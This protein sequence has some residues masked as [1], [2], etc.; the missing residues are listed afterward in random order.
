[1]FTTDPHTKTTPAVGGVSQ[2]GAVPYGRA[3]RKCLNM[4]EGRAAQLWA[5]FAN[6][7]GRLDNAALS[8]L[9]EVL[10]GYLYVY[11]HTVY[12]Y[13]FRA[14]ARCCAGKQLSVYNVPGR[15]CTYVWGVH[16]AQASG[17]PALDKD[18]YDETC[19]GSQLWDA[20]A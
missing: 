10:K 6:A 13:P 14:T 11:I 2:G 16:A 18:Y 12:K 3:A 15:P 17:S 9:A 7:D 19:E 1:M 8:R 4:R 20:D 5:H